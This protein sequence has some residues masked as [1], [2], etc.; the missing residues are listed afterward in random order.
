MT[1]LLTS[2]FLL[3]ELRGSEVRAEVSWNSWL[4]SYL[5]I[6]EKSLKIEFAF[7]TMYT[8]SSLGANWKNHWSLFKNKEWMEFA[9]LSRLKGT[10]FSKVYEM[11]LPGGRASLSTAFTITI[12]VAWG[13][14]HRLPTARPGQEK[15]SF[16]EKP[17]DN[18]ATF[19]IHS[20]GIGQFPFWKT[21]D[22]GDLNILNMFPKTPDTGKHNSAG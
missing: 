18:A 15:S 1:T 10:A 8:L 5:S 2:L 19:G 21:T 14:W 11:T 12:T 6:T 3:R 4:W 17:M 7:P 9:T 13:W 16:T 22:T 20:P